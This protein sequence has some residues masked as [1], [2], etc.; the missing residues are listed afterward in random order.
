MK[1]TRWAFVVV[2]LITLVLLIGSTILQ[3]IV[4]KAAETQA[5][6]YLDPPTFVVKPA[7]SISLN[8]MANF[9]DE[10][11]FAAG[12]FVVS[13]DAEKLIFQSVEASNGFATKKT[14]V[15]NNQLSWL[16]VP[17]NSGDVG[18]IDGQVT[19]GKINF[20][21]K[22]AGVVA[23]G[24]DA[25]QAIISAIDTTGNFSLYNAVQSV[26]GA[27][28][29]IKD[30]A[31]SSKISPPVTANI[32]KSLY[33]L[34]NQ[35][36]VRSQHF[37]LVDK[38]L[39]AVNLKESANVR[40]EFG[41][42]RNL[43]SSAETV[44]ASRSHLIELLGLSPQSTYYYQLTVLD[45]NRQPVISSPL[46]SFNTVS[47]AKKDTPIS[48]SVSEIAAIWPTTTSENEVITVLKNSDG[49]IIQ[50]ESAEFTLVEGR[51]SVVPIEKDDYLRATV[52]SLINQK[53]SVTI[54]L[55]VRD[56]IIAETKFVFDPAQTSLSD[57]PSASLKK[58]DLTQQA[59][60]NIAALV[61]IIILSGLAL[62]R[63]I[64]VN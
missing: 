40:V 37:T 17:E 28:G 25:G 63:F 32:L 36:I 33:P 61:V 49:Q 53:Q 1:S 16:I 54:G 6:V 31:I 29:E 34:T 38:S 46:R 3:R 44:S 8:L 4:F 13:Y 23:V 9:S 55:K 12:Q 64:K 59:V 2:S 41:Q 15:V 14:T 5:T 43:G 48:P 30:Q 20:T 57:S 42:T 56:Q 27:L 24:L 47:F 58:F 39:V 51:A 18:R 52:T 45:N 7:G 35:Q 50:P 19:I 22:A 60:I 10:T 21:S 11:F 26:Q 62:V